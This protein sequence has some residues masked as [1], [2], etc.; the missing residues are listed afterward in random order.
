MTEVAEGRKLLGLP[1][2]LCVH[3][4][5]PL[6]ESL[7]KSYTTDE[8]F[9]DLSTTRR[10]LRFGNSGYGTGCC[11]NVLTMCFAEGTEFNNA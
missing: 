11:I 8:V 2:F 10:S 6:W 3:D 9:P 4:L 7:S 1:P 5:T